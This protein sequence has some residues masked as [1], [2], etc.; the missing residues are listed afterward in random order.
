M[1]HHAPQNYVCPICLGVQGVENDQTLILQ[2]DIL[3]KDDEVMVFIASFFVLGAEGHLIVVPT[4][5]Y[6]HFYELP[7]EIGSKIIQTAKEY[8]IKMK[9]TYDCDGINVLQNNEP[10]AGQHAYHYHLHLFPRYEG[11]DIWSNMGSKFLA[12]AKDR[13]EFAQ[14]FKERASIS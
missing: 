1:L 9:K 12:S 6:E 3:Y 4:K 5:H 13:F 2:Q 10:A 7:D 14:R 8:S 11:K